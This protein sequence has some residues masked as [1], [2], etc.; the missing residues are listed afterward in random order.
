MASDNIP[1][2]DAL[3]PLLKKVLGSPINNCYI[4]IGETTLDST[5]I[6]GLCI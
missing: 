4:K 2:G 3:S 5:M 1:Q 6:W